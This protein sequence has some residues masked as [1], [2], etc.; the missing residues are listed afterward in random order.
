MRQFVRIAILSA[1]VLTMTLMSGCVIEP[2]RH[3]GYYH[4]W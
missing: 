4:C 1:G 2:G 3:C